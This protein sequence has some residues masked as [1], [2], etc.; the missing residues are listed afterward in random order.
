MS[1]PALARPRTT[2]ATPPAGSTP[3]PFDDLLARATEIGER[4]RSVAAEREAGGRELFAEVDAL[5]SSGVLGAAVPVRLGGPAVG[6]GHDVAPSQRAELLRV[7]AYGN[8]SLAQ[9]AQPHFVFARWLVEDRGGVRPP[10]AAVWA[11]RLLG[12]ALVSNAQAER[13]PHVAVTPVGGTKEVR[14]D[15]E[16]H[17]CTGSPYADFFAVSAFHHGASD[18]T[19]PDVLA[20]ADALAP[21]LA[22]VDE[23]DALGQRLTGSGRVRLGGVRVQAADVHPFDL[24][25]LPAYG[26]FAQLLHAAIDVGLAEAALDE[27]LDLARRAGIG[28]ELTEHLAGELASRAF[29]AGAVLE[30]AG[31]AVDTAVAAGVDTD[32]RAALAVGA[33]KATTGEL[34]VDLASRVFELTGTRGI[35]PHAELDRRWRDLRT[36]TLH[37][38]RRDKLRT[39]GRA[40]LTGEPPELG[41]QF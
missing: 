26:A 35:A 4:A 20:F 16:K 41:T 17:F 40:F 12:G 28:G 31:R 29:A 22:L 27:A 30:A 33:A 39:L 15:G 2:A 18:S 8:G 21:G 36:H 24:A 5:K 23:W 9:I 37:E 6:D 32:G 25:A 7:L 13:G 3:D 19:T 10:R 1:A 38:R 14:L 34:T 11:D